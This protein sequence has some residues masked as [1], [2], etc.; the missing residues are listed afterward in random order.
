MNLQTLN[1]EPTRTTPSVAFH[2]EQQTLAI[3]GQSYPE[4]SFD[5]Y[6]PIIHWVESH[7]KANP[8]EPLC[9]E[10]RLDYFN[11]SSSKC[12]LDLLEA[13]EAHHNFHQNVRI[14]WC[15]DADDEDMEDNGHD[16]KEDLN[17]PFE[18]CPGAL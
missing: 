11:T 1:I 18:M 2:P 7:L 3:S 8:V 12:I 4:N 13:L 15:Y 9:V 10:F 14:K 5:F 6:D 16:F 17:L